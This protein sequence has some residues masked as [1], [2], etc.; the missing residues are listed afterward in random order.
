MSAL[1]SILE[2]NKKFVAN[3]EYKKID[4]TTKIP[5]KE[6]VIVSCM[7]TRLTELLVKSMNI[8][9]GDAKIIKVAGAVI[10]S[11]FGSVMRSIIVA[12]HEL[13]A[14]EIIVVGHEDCGMAAIDPDSM[15]MKMTE[16]GIP[17][18][19]LELIE[20]TGVNLHT[21]LTA[22][23]SVEASVEASVKMVRKHPLI[24]NYVKIS[25]LVIH[26]DTGLLDFVVDAR[27][28]T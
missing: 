5:K 14:D 7:D 21:W 2:F 24:P 26:P 19:R 20:N 22:F 3:Q 17:R 10:N 25:G 15:I 8:K 9:N 16:N 11:P 12:V 6:L 27:E 13:G 1:D 4:T 28:T 18:E 23:S